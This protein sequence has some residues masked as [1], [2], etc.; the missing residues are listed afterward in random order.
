MVRYRR[1]LHKAPALDTPQIQAAWELVVAREEGRAP[2]AHALSVLA[3]AFLEI[4]D[5]EHPKNIFGASVGLAV[6]PGRPCDHGITGGDVVSAFI[7]LRRREIA[8]ENPK[9]AL[10]SAKREA[11][12]SFP[13]FHNTADAERAIDRDWASGRKTV[14]SLSTDDLRKLLDLHIIVE[15]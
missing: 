5:G 12:V 9:G 6:K 8:E 11:G 2:A 15:K 3:D 14:E 4:I 10:E 7:E 1:K 13:F